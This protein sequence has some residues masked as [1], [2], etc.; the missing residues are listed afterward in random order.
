MFS[1]VFRF[2]TAFGR[3]TKSFYSKVDTAILPYCFISIWVF[4]FYSVVKQSNS[5]TYIDELLG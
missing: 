2:R 4:N 1:Y 3:P 5:I